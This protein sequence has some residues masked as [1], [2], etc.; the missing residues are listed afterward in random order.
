MKVAT[1]NYIA[2]A[3]IFSPMAII[4]LGASVGLDIDRVGRT[5]IGSAIGLT[6]ASLYK[7]GQRK[8]GKEDRRD[9]LG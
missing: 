7:L 1:R 8:L 9:R 5:I 4:W 3:L 6:L 2:L